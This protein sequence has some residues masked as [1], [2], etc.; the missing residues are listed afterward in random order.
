MAAAVLVMGNDKR[1]KKYYFGTYS[2]KVSQRLHQTAWLFPILKL[3]CL[4]RTL[5][6]LKFLFD[7]VSKSS[8]AWYCLW[9][10]TKKK[11]SVALCPQYTSHY[12]SENC[13][14]VWIS[15]CL[16]IAD[17]WAFLTSEL[18]SWSWGYCLE[19]FIL[20]TTRLHNWVWDCEPFTVLEQI[21]I[22]AF[23]NFRNTE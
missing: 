18:P 3:Q 23:E 16:F 22:S 12:S 10:L 14:Y 4:L 19:H 8:E 15:E 9:K 13:S 1:R 7:E 5:L 11:F 6:K 21:G 20:M 2:F 17:R